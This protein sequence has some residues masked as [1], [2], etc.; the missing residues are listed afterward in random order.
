MM[1]LSKLSR[2]ERVA[3]LVLALVFGFNVYRFMAVL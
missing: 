3:A 2:N 1:K